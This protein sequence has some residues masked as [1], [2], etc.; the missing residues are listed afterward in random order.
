GAPPPR[1]SHPLIMSFSSTNPSIVQASHI[2]LRYPAQ[3]VRAASESGKFLAAPE[4][5]V[6]IRT[7]DPPRTDRFVKEHRMDGF[8]WARSLALA[9]L[10]AVPAASAS[11]YV[12]KTPDTLVERVRQTN[13]RFKDV[14]VAVAE[15]Y[16]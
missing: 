15:G 7:D 1:P 13:D 14:S 16:R 11:E 2:R 5:D 4:R 6:D 10:L 8:R 3:P 9:S 12:E